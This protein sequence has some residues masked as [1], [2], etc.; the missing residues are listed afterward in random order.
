MEIKSTHSEKSLAKIMCVARTRNV[1]KNK[2]SQKFS[3]F[4]QM[5][6]VQS[7]SRNKASR[8]LDINECFLIYFKAVAN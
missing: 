6:N 7:V 4:V 3:Q 2:H 1:R 8:E 5:P